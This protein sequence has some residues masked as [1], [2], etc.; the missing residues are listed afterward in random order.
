MAGKSVLLMRMAE[1]QRR[2][3][4]I[5]ALVR[6]SSAAVLMTAVAVFVGIE[7]EQRVSTRGIALIFIVA[8]VV[9]AAR[10]GFGAG[11]L[12]AMAAFLALNYFFIEPRHTF[13]ITDQKELFSLGIFLIVAAITG[14]LA[15][16]LREQA[17]S[18]SRRADMLQILSDFSAMLAAAGSEAE[19]L[20][21]LTVH[22]SKAV[23]GPAALFRQDGE[24]PVLEAV[25]PKGLTIDLNETQSAEQVFRKGRAVM[26][27]APGWAGG[28]FEYRFVDK[29]RLPDRVIALAPKG[30]NRAVAADAEQALS[31]LME[32]ASL[33]VERLR[34][35][36]AGV[37]ARAVAQEEKLRST[38]L[39][40]VSHDLR[41]PLAAI[42]GS[43]T[44]LREF[45]GGMSDK[46]QGELLF[47]IEDETR[48]LSR[49]VA[50]LLDMTKLQ[51]GLRLRKD[52]ADVSEIVQASVAAIRISAPDRRFETAFNGALPPLLCDAVLLGQV[53]YN[54]LENAAKFSLPET[55]VLICGKFLPKGI[56][57]KVID[58]GPGIAALDL[59]LVFDKF[60]SRAPVS[61]G[62]EGTGLGL[63]IAKGIVE[64]MGG[65]IRAVSPGSGGNGTEM[66]VTL[67]LPHVE[68]A[69]LE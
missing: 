50:N 36:K 44:T 8:V 10:M 53:F 69:V 20:A 31:T 25:C 9:C 22:V 42:L 38:L 67:P 33:A 68:A 40:S 43:V 15:G 64:E 18:A 28:R 62:K 17:V 49:Q 59:P 55:P 34:F 32:Q 52:W 60:F 39:S 2:S 66:I 19:I 13:A 7:L 37:A 29:H 21:E 46:A 51:S 26:A 65:A 30:G 11:I 16:R 5:G 57:I 35:S 4:Q 23:E 61:M 63:A 3:D 56:E 27:T 14:S 24:I 45:G 54:L 6:A 41:T 48:R 47:A 1:T 58:Q 12:S